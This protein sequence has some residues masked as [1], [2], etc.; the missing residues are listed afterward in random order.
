MKNNIEDIIKPHLEVFTYNIPEPTWYTSIYSGII[1]A[2]NT[3][4]ARFLA[5][6]IIRTEIEAVNNILEDH[7][8]HIGLGLENDSVQVQ[9]ASEYSNISIEDQELTEEMIRTYIKNIPDILHNYGKNIQTGF[10]KDHLSRDIEGFN[11]L[12]EL[13]QQ[14]F[15]VDSERT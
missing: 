4:E 6:K 15:I 13:L 3:E 8:H 12:S 7:N 1:A 14:V 2:L 11:K 10:F 9:L 5:E